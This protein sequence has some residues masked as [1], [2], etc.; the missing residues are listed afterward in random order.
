MADAN[1]NLSELRFGCL[2]LVLL[3]L[4]SVAVDLARAQP[5][6]SPWQQLQE[7]AEK[8]TDILIRLNDDSRND[9]RKQMHLLCDAVYERF[10]LAQTARL[11]LA[12]H[13]EKRSDTEKTAFIALFGR[14]LESAYLSKAY[15]YDGEQVVFIREQ[16]QTSRAQVHVRVYHG[17][18]H[19]PIT[20]RMHLTGGGQWMVYDVAAFGVSLVGNLRAQFNHIINRHSYEQVIRIMKEKTA[21]RSACAELF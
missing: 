5:A 15:R 17:M 19:I 4:C 2:V 12:D 11:S 21:G 20:V 9:A 6:H 8:M 10:S 3:L 13:W 7:T 1:I 18:L 14:F 16:I